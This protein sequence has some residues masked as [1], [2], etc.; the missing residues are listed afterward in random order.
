M[1]FSGG[2]PL[3]QAAF[4]LAAA[5]PPAAPPGV[6]T[7]V[8]TCGFAPARGAA[9]ARRALADLVL[10]DLKLP[11]R[12]A[13]TA[14]SPALPT[15]R[16]STTCGRSRR[17]TPTIWLR[18]PVVPGSTTTPGRPR[19]DRRRS[20]PACRGCGRSACCRTTARARASAAGSAARPRSPASPRRRPSAS[21][22]SPRLVPRPRPRRPRSEARTHERAHRRACA[23]E[24]LDAAPRSPAERALL[25]TE[26][27]R[28]HDGRF[29][30]PG[31]AGARRSAT[32][33]SARRSGSATAS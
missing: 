22:R 29:S 26:F 4:L 17:R 24:S 3:A 2:E 8:D 33:A 20:R 7:A 5:R 18:V 14:R 9:R 12:R 11:R 1:T 31:A 13:R 27:Y 25:L 10:Y 30:D 16:S 15:R 32:C 19:G 28:E 23:Q 6:H 21:R